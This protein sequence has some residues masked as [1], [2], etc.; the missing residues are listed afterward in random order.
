MG[1]EMCIRDRSLPELSSE[2]KGAFASDAFAKF[3]EEVG[4]YRK[5]QNVMTVTPVKGW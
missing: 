4:G 5:V 3:A 2:T 1:S